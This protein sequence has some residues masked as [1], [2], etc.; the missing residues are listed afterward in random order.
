MI[1]IINYVSVKTSVQQLT[2]TGSATEGPPPY[3]ITS[4]VG[5]KV[6]EGISSI[7]F[8]IIILL[9]NLLLNLLQK[10]SCLWNLILIL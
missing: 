9:L 4:D 3:I 7:L 1:I 10:L 8:I 5:S 6:K 2:L